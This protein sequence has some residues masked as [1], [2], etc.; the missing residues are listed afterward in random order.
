V[1]LAIVL[2]LVWGGVKIHVIMVVGV[3]VNIVVKDLV[4]RSVK[5]VVNM[6]VEVLLTFDNLNYRKRIII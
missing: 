5:G 1:D 3:T 6:A 2:I 4:G